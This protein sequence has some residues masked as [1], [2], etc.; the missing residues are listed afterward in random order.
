MGNLYRPRR[1][2]GRT[3][4]NPSFLTPTQLAARW[5]VHFTTLAIWRGQR[6][7]GLNKG[8]KFFKVGNLVRYPLEEVEAYEGGQ[9]L[10]LFGEEKESEACSSSV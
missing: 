8:P 5:Q 9:Q 2:M 7:R 3:M 1:E 10:S 4:N 6:K